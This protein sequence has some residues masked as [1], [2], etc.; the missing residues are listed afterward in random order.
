MFDKIRLPSTDYPF[1]K[2][3]L[4]SLTM[5]VICVF[6]LLYY[7]MKTM[8]EHIDIRLESPNSHRSKGT[9]EVESAGQASVINM[10]S[11]A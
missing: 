9:A 10:V 11:T 5:Q 4:V 2:H 7:A 6:L 3:D 1:T 8:M